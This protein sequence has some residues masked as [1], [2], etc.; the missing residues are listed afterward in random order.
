VGKAAGSS[1]APPER[2]L[3]AWAAGV[4]ALV[5]FGG[6]AQT[7]YFK[8]VF[9]TPV[10]S[11][12]LL[13]HGVVMSLWFILLL[14]QLRL[15]AVG[16]TDLHRRL[17]AIGAVLF[18]TILLVGVA[19]AIEAARRG[20]SPAPGVTPLMFMA[21][22]LA[23]MLVFGVLVGAALWNRRHSATHKRLMVL[24]SLAIL[25]PGIAR[26]PVD[27]IGQGGLPVVFGLTLL[28]VAACVAIDSVINRRLHPAFGWGGILV[29]ASVPLRIALAG[30]EGWNRF[31]SWLVG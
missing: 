11:P 22:P 17:G 19:T 25:A 24:A 21:V 23:D 10:L 14:V 8:A 18:V 3:W 12:L 20:A 2:R 26:L 5:I 29:V 16:R 4:A 15:V 6:F 27:F 1:A 7:F 9:G 13:A 31:A 28:G 30:T